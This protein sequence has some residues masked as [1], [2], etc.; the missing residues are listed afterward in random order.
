MTKVDFAAWHSG[1]NQRALD[2][3]E[4]VRVK[5]VEGGGFV[6]PEAQGGDQRH[7]GYEALAVG[8]Q[9]RGHHAAVGVA[10]QCCAFDPQGGHQL[11]VEEDEVPK[12]V[13]L[14]QPDG[15]GDSR[16]GWCVDVEGL[17]EG[18]EER[19]PAG[20][21][22]FSMEVEEVGAGASVDHLDIELSLSQGEH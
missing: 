18:V 5:K 11:F 8:S 4:G 6:E 21:A 7:P 2:S 20:E 12:V 3:S 9:L 22:L 1:S 14:F 13:K 10:D 19:G 15:L 17:G 16:V